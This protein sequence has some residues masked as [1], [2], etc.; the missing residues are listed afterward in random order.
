[1]GVISTYAVALTQILCYFMHL[2]AINASQSTIHAKTG[3]DKMINMREN[4]FTSQERDALTMPWKVDENNSRTDKI[5]NMSQDYDIFNKCIS[6]DAITIKKNRLKAIL[7]DQ[8]S[9]AYYE[10][11]VFPSPKNVIVEVKPKKELPLCEGYE[12]HMYLFIYIY[13]FDVIM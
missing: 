10:I 6:A 5:V 4:I 2:C 13:Y 8:G 11:E 7:N 12:K 3:S 9:I 1:M